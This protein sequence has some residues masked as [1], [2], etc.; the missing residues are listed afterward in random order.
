VTAIEY[1]GWLGNACFFGRV[2]LQW[3]G[4]E[5]RRT[6]EAPRLFWLLSIA[7]SILLS[8]FAVQRGTWILLVGFAVN[9][10][11]YTRNLQLG[12]SEGHGLPP[13]KR[14][15]FSLAVAAALALVVAGMAHG[16]FSDRETWTWT[17]LAILGQAIW[18]SRFVVQWLASERDGQSYFPPAFWVSSL[19]GNVLLLVYAVH[20][21]E[22][23]FIAG[24]ALGPIVQIRNLWLT[25]RLRAAPSSPPETPA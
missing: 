18:S 12:S 1:V 24:L 23:V 17:A 2:A 21:W 4:V 3:V 5:R 8:A 10:L 7:G 25:G 6:R 14:V 9:G 15:A 16:P 20:L 11:I 19:I 22:A 13:T